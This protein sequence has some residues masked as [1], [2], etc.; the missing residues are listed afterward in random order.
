[1]NHA[2]T[3]SSAQIAEETIK[4]TLTSVYSGSTDSIAIGIAIN[5]KNYMRIGVNQ[6]AQL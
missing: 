1:M 4:Q 3:P 6:F 5:N 2:L